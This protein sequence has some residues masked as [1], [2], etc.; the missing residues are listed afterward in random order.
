MDNNQ[1]P[2][3]LIFSMTYLPFIGGAEMAVKEITDR[4]DDFNFDLITARL[5]KKLPKFEKIG[6][7]NIYRVGSGWLLDK[8]LFPWLAYFKAK[9]LHQKRNYQIVQAIMAFY[10]G[11]AALFFK[12]RYPQ[13][14][15]LLT[16]QSGDSDFF[17]WLRTWFWHPLYRKIYTKPDYIQVISSFLEKRARKYGYKKE[18]EIVP[19]GVDLQKFKP[20]NSNQNLK[21]KLGIKQDEKVIIHSGR[22]AKKNGLDDLIKASLY[23]DSSI[24]ILIMGDGPDRKK[25]EDLAEK[26][27]TKER[28]I[29]LGK[30]NNDDLPKYLVIADIF[31]RPSL[32]EG[33]GISFLEAMAASTPV[34]GTQVGGILDFLK[35]GKTGLFCEVRNPKSIAEKIGEILEN[36]PLRKTLAKNGLKLVQDKYNWDKIV[37]KMEKIFKNLST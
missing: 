5:D 2:R 12:W 29:F 23:L 21:L 36:S 24:K 17:I 25:L 32:S 14:K 7:L 18:I 20:K 13:V 37:S 28:V 11:L 10:A 22:I 33:Q 35:D 4:I 19:N 27:K 15:Y 31:V 30:Y 8:Y 6:N 26:L 34:I 3:I 1:E 9:K 16:M